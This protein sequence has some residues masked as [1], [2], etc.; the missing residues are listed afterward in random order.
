MVGKII[1]YAIAVAVGK[2]IEES[3]KLGMAFS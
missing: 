3:N 2:F 1:D